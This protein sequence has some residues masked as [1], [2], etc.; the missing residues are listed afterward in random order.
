MNFPVGSTVKNLPTSAG[1]V[2][3]IPGLV[4]SVKKEMATHSSIL[5]LEIPLREGVAKELD[6]PWQLNKNT[7][8]LTFNEVD[9]IGRKQK[10]LYLINL[11]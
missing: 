8:I 1:A 5:A 6:I 11:T 10:Q 7:G 2:S 9:I 3:S 4:R